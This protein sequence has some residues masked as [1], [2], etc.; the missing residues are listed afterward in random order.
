MREGHAPRAARWAILIWIGVAFAVWN[1]FFDILV[2]RGEKQYLLAQ[3]RH[4][5]GLGPRPTLD[6]VMGR[7]IRDARTNASI[8]AGIVLAAGVTT[9]AML[10]RARPRSRLSSDVP[11]PRSDP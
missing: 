8:W 4:E 5:L 7:T 10:T 1:G 2:T 6:E 11:T 3:A 9:T